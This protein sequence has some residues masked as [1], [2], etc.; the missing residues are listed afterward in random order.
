MYSDED[1]YC[2]Q[3]PY[4]CGATTAV[5]TSSR[6]LLL[7]ARDNIAEMFYLGAS[8]DCNTDAAVASACS[9]TQPA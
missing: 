3:P 7:R 5:M 9:K 6:L 8:P 4:V 1:G 2:T